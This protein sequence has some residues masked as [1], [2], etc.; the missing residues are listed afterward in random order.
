MKTNRIKK[1]FAQIKQ[2]LVSDKLKVV[3][4]DDVPHLLSSLGLLEEFNSGEVKCTCCSKTIDI[5]NFA[6]LKFVN[7]KYEFYCTNENCICQQ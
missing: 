3:Y 5:E 6:Y 2:R 7:G 4:D 1:L